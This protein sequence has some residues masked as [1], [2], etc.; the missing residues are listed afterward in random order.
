LAEASEMEMSPLT[1]GTLNFSMAAGAA[2]VAGEVMRAA[3]DAT[4][5]AV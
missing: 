2:G 4:Y 5:A 1:E 3:R